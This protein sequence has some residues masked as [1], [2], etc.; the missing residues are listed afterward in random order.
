MEVGL[1]RFLPLGTSFVA[2]SKSKLLDN[3]TPL[4]FVGEQPM[5]SLLREAMKPSLSQKS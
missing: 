4:H 3:L 5:V 2:R 1:S